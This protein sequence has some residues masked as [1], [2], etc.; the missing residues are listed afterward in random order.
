MKKFKKYLII[1]L[2]FIAVLALVTG[3]DLFGGA[4]SGGG[5]TSYLKVTNASGSAD[6]YIS[7]LYI[8]TGIDPF[9]P[10]TWG[11]DLINNSIPDGYYSMF[12]FDSG[13]V[14]ILVWMNDLDASSGD[15]FW[16]VFRDNES[17]SDGDTHTIRWTS[18]NTFSHYDYE[19]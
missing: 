1:I 5:G 13:T 12:E 4:T 10:G 15:Y 3:C 17:F 9:S 7:E 18:C 2:S 8:G 11:T 14:D 6:C 19:Y 16:Y